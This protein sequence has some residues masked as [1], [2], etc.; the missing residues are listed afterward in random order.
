MNR[1]KLLWGKLKVV[2][3]EWHEA[4]EGCIDIHIPL[5]FYML[6]DTYDDKT[7]LLIRDAIYKQLI[8]KNWPVE[9]LDD[10]YFSY[11]NECYKLSIM[12]KRRST[13]RFY[14]EKM[15]K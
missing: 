7:G 9:S 10:L 15:D 4:Y 8:K 2:K 13:V 14:Q 5:Q 11:A 12:T 6:H 3:A 1:G